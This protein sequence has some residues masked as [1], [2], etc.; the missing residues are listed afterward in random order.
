MSRSSRLTR[1]SSSSRLVNSLFPTESGGPAGDDPFDLTL[2]STRIDY[3]EILD[4]KNHSKL[5]AAWDSMLHR[6]FLP[7]GL[8]SVLQFYFTAE[9]DEAQTFPALQIPLPPNTRLYEAEA[10]AKGAGIGLPTLPEHPADVH[11]LGIP[12][13]RALSGHADPVLEDYHR[14]AESGPAGAVTSATWA[15]MHLAK[16]V[17]LVQGCKAVVWEAYRDLEPAA[18]GVHDVRDEFQA[19]WLNWEW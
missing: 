1:K 15:H 19:A 18:A 13:L 2:G 12:A 9:F 17:A 6:R 5:K 8:L 4:P 14:L 3:L 16:V 11:E 10:A 7:S